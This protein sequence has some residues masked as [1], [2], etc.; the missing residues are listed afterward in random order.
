MSFPWNALIAHDVRCEAPIAPVRGYSIRA[1]GKNGEIVLYDEIG[2]SFWGGGISAQKFKNDLD[3]LGKVTNI[4]LRIN[5]PGGQVFDGMTIY[6]LLAQHPA[7]ITTHVDGLAASIASVIAMAGDEIRIAD[8]AMMMIHNASGMCMGTAGDM[9][10]TA[11]LL[12]TVSNTIQGVYAKRSG[13]DAADIGKMMD[14]ETWMTAEDAVKCGLA[15]RV[16]DSMNVTAL[17]DLTKYPFKKLPNAL[18]ASIDPETKAGAHPNR[19]R[20]AAKFEVMKSRQI[21]EQT[22][23]RT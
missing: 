10:S 15:D 23:R 1:A 21:R 19:K 22:A 4:D 20:F 2:E 6:N 7:R 14:D 5:S 11:N 17:G 12:D 3:A 16:V 13:T 8:N 9:R 18:L